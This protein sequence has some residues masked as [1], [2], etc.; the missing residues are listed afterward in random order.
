MNEFHS[1]EKRSFCFYL[2][3]ITVSYRDSQSYLNLY[4]SGY[5]IKYKYK[6]LIQV[7]KG[8][9]LCSARVLISF[10]TYFISRDWFD[11]LLIIEE[12]SSWLSSISSCWEISF[13]TF[14]IFEKCF[15]N[16]VYSKTRQL[17]FTLLTGNMLSIF[18]S[19]LPNEKLY[20]ADFILYF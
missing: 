17:I 9:F 15:I 11:E 5:Q 18:D 6:F 10:I 2:Y 8:T 19:R 13:Y 16:N 7:F 3:G 1:K 12:Q 20:Q 4:L 14:I